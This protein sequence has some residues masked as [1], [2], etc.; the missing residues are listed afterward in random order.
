MPEV[1]ARLTC[2]SFSPNSS[3]SSMSVSFGCLLRSVLSLISLGSKAI[4]CPFSLLWY[5]VSG[6]LLSRELPAL[7]AGEPPRV[8]SSFSPSP[9]A[10]GPPALAPP[11]LLVSPDAVDIVCRVVM[12]LSSYNLRQQ[13]NRP[14]RRA[15]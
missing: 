8:R 9:P 4:L 14:Q 5:E 12:V 10:L 6:A 13:G 2:L 7:G 3:T 11:L 15:N 1:Y